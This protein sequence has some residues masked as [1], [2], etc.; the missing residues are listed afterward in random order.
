[1]I[2]KGGKERPRP[3][4]SFLLPLCLMA[5]ADPCWGQR[6]ALWASVTIFSPRPLRTRASCCCSSLDVSTSLVGPTG[7]H[8]WETPLHSGLEL[9]EL[10]SLACYNPD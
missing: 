9:A 5:V 6:R 1:M 10:D 7:S 3:G 8:F 2:R 4:I